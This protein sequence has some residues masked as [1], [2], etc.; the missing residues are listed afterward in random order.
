MTLNGSHL[1][2]PAAHCPPHRPPSVNDMA[3]SK[4]DLKLFYWCIIC[5]Q[6][7]HLYHI[8]KCH[9]VTNWI[10]HTFTS[11]NCF[12]SN[13]MFFGV[14]SFILGLFFVF[15]FLQTNISFVYCVNIVL[16]AKTPIFLFTEKPAI[17]PPVFVFQK[18]KGQKVRGPVCS[19]FKFVFP[20]GLSPQ[21]TWPSMLLPFKPSHW[22]WRK[23][24]QWLQLTTVWA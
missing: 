15:N 1:R 9:I 22:A 10:L 4:W 7:R 11:W 3:C 8:V 12:L 14:T 13:L 2:C 20:R 21:V 6:K 5:T 24:V 19:L 18:D 16:R 17:A 23:K